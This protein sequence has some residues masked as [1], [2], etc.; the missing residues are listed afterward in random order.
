LRSKIFKQIYQYIWCSQRWRQLGLERARLTYLTM[1]SLILLLSSLIASL[2]PTSTVKCVDTSTEGPLSYED[3]LRGN[4]VNISRIEEHIRF[5][6]LNAAP[7]VT[8]YPGFYE[9]QEY[10][11]NKFNE[12]GLQNVQYQWYNITIPVDLGG[13]LTIH[14]PDGTLLKTY[15]VSTFGQTQSKSLQPRPEA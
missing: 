14:S 4:Y 9:A 7:R 6:T 5:F 10:I 11:Y 13:T 3:I 15:S 12:Y 1:V 8:G 2:I